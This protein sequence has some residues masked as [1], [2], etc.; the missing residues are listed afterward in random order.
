MRY[1]LYDSEKNVVN[2]II[3]D[4][5]FATNYCARNGYTYEKM[6]ELEPDS[7]PTPEPSAEATVWDELD[8]AY[9]EGVDSV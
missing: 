4:E 1:V 3:A 6:P 5:T 9:Q 7:E 2:T 8:A